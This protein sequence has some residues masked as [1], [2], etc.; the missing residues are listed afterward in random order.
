[1]YPVRPG[2]PCP[3]IL[4]IG[5]FFDRD[6]EMYSCERVAQEVTIDP[7][8]AERYHLY[9]GM[10]YR[11]WAAGESRGANLPDVWFD[12]ESEIFS[13]ADVEAAVARNATAARHYHDGRGRLYADV[14]GR[15]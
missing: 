8:A 3:V 10:T 11:E 13:L 6:G 7:S 5:C 9:G 1:M 2:D 12:V 14:V 4:L 15:G